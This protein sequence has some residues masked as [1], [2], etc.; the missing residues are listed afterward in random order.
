[1]LEKSRLEVASL[2]QKH[3]S[4]EEKLETQAA[5]LNHCQNDLKEARRLAE[6]RT[7]LFAEL[8]KKA[9]PG[10]VTTPTLN[11]RG[12]QAPASMTRGISTS[13][14]RSLDDA[15]AD[16]ANGLKKHD[17]IV[18]NYSIFLHEQPRVVL[19]AL[20]GNSLKSGIGDLRQ[21]VVKRD[22]EF[23]AVVHWKVRKRV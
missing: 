5:E 21:R 22:S 11:K 15:R 23:S 13:L 19:E 14:A 12:L 3:S 6:E 20:L 9:A 16:A 7:E 2:T 1:M 10:S 17:E 8:K 18:H 4:L